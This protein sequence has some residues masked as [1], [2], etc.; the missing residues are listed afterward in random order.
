LTLWFGGDTTEPDAVEISFKYKTESGE[1]AK[2]IA[3]RA[4]SL[5]VAMQ[6]GLSG[7]RPALAPKTALGLPGNC[8]E[9]SS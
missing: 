2:E 1:V 8:R 7:S 3:R 4:M 6:S 5:S 9:G